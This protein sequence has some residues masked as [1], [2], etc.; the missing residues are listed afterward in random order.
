MKEIKGEGRQI[1]VY[2]DRNAKANEGLKVKNG[3]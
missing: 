3:R 2:K 1:K